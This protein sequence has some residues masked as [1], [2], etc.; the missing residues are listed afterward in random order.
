M[1][2]RSPIPE[3]GAK[4][5]AITILPL[6]FFGMHGKTMRET[7]DC[8]KALSDENGP[9][10]HADRML[11][12]I[13]AD[14]PGGGAVRD[15]II[16]YERQR[17]MSAVL[18]DAKISDVFEEDIRF[19]VGVVRGLVIALSVRQEAAKALNRQG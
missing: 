17:A 18:R 6:C 13:A 4:W 5:H 15:Q 14:E 9:M 19:K 11:R 2:A 1:E 3:S 8:L 7:A 10:P 16:E 12:S